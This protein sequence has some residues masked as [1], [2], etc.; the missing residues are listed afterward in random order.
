[1]AIDKATSAEL[2]IPSVVVDRLLRERSYIPCCDKMLV[3]VHNVFIGIQ[4]CNFCDAKV[5][6]FSFLF[7]YEHIFKA[8]DDD[9][10]YIVIMFSNG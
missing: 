3:L 6:F 9:M 1:M 10:T 7:R 2:S 8:S 4:S 5:N